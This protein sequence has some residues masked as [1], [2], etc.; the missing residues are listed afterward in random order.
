MWTERGRRRCR[1]ARSEHPDYVQHHV[2]RSGGVI[3]VERRI[4]PEPNDHKVWHCLAGNEVEVGSVGHLGDVTQVLKQGQIARRRW[5]GCGD[6]EDHRIDAGHGTAVLVQDL[7]GIRS[8]ALQRAAPIWI[9]GIEEAKWGDDG[10]EKGAEFEGTQSIFPTDLSEEL[11]KRIQQVAV[12]SF[13][14]LRLRDYARIDLRVTTSGEICVIEINPN[15]YL[16]RKAEFAR[17][18]DKCGLSYH[19]LVGKIEHALAEQKQ[20]EREKDREYWMPLNAE[21]ESLRHNR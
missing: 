18:A 13:Q 5:V 10:D 19:A 7:N 6:I 16:E 14:A 15:C 4:G 11:T 21:V 12:D 8:V 1:I 3:D 20:R 17:A 9:A 2:D